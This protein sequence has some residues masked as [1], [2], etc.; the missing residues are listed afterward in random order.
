[1]DC[2]GCRTSRARFCAACVN[3]AILERHTRLHEFSN[4]KAAAAASMS[5]ALDARERILLKQDSRRSH[6]VRIEQMRAELATTQHDADLL[7]DRVYAL[8][9]QQ[10]QRKAPLQPGAGAGEPA[11]LERPAPA[12]ASIDARLTEA[13]RELLH[14][15]L[16]FQRQLWAGVDIRVGQEDEEPDGAAALPSPASSTSSASSGRRVAGA[17]DSPLVPRGSPDAWA[18]PVLVRRG[19][20]AA[21]GGGSPLPATGAVGGSSGSSDAGA[22]PLMVRAGLGSVL[23]S[24]SSFTSLTTL[25][26]PAGTLPSLPSRDGSAPP[27][28]AALRASTE[29]GQA[30]LALQVCRDRGLLM[31]SARFT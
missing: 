10:E 26:T 1:M 15:L 3:Q 20:G 7:R 11:H 13:R 28:L 6:Q 16:E 29:L 22:S 8:R 19:D 24:F 9:Q 2:W 27:S 14:R 17:A 5:E 31:I 25:T 23:G 12:V 4:D 30:V 18:S 21:A